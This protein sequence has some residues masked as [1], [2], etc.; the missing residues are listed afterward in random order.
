MKQSLFEQRLEELGYRRKPAGRTEG[1]GYRN[2][3]TQYDWGQ[4]RRKPLCRRRI[5]TGQLVKYWQGHRTVK[6]LYCS[7]RFPD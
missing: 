6:C 2:L 1:R 4:P 7:Y 5:H 3:N